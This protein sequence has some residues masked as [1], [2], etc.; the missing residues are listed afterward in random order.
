[1][2][3]AKHVGC[4]V[5]LTPCTLELYPLLLGTSP[6]HRFLEPSIDNVKPSGYTTKGSY[7]R[8]DEICIGF[9]HI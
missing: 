3:L 9:H 6:P 8:R 1:M 2:T 4:T 5:E 7:L